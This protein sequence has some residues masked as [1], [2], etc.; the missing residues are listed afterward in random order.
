MCSLP[1]VYRWVCMLQLGRPGGHLAWCAQT[2]PPLFFLVKSFAAKKTSPLLCLA[3]NLLSKQVHSHLVWDQM[4][5]G[6]WRDETVCKAR[7]FSRSRWRDETTMGESFFFF[8]PLSLPTLFFSK[9]HIQEMFRRALRAA[10][11]V[12]RYVL[13][14][15]S[16]FIMT[17]RPYRKACA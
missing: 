5:R 8:N 1:P 13:T 11:C 7:L 12:V 9:T 4:H 3:I 2:F 10:A 17:L 14:G 16:A 6:S 15:A